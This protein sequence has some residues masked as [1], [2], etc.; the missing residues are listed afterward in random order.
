M[1]NVIFEEEVKVIE[2]ENDVTD[3]IVIALV[4]GVVLVALIYLMRVNVYELIFK[5]F[6]FVNIYLTNVVNFVSGIFSYLHL[7]DMTNQI[8]QLF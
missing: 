8:S 4:L 1:K 6:D 5:G 7:G 3:E 2:K